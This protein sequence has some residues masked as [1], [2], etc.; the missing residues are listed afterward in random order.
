LRFLWTDDSRVVPIVKHSWT[1]N[2]PTPGQVP[3]LTAA[4]SFFG[5]QGKDPELC[6]VCA[7][8]A[9]PASSSVSVGSLTC[10]PRI[11]HDFRRS[12]QLRA[13]IHSERYIAGRFP[14]AS[15]LI[16]CDTGREHVSRH[17]C[18]SLQ[19]AFSLRCFR[20]LFEPSSLTRIRSL[21]YSVISSI[22]CYCLQRIDKLFHFLFQRYLNF[23]SRYRSYLWLLNRAKYI[24]TL[25][26]YRISN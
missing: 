20:C 14:S 21:F 16:V 13:A 3:R 8:T 22:A 4:A 11:S 6:A 9:Y 15:K 7:G 19:S 18:C 17:R 25:F 1:Q 10:P 5:S 2:T 24:F 26:N 23:R 12:P